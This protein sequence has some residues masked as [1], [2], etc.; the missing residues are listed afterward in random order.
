MTEK[1]VIA[2][3]NAITIKGKTASVR[4][5]I[6]DNVT[7]SANMPVS[8]IYHFAGG[9]LNHKNTSKDAA[10]TAQ[11]AEISICDWAYAIIEYAANIGTKTE[12]A[13]PS[14]PSITDVENT[15]SVTKTNKG[16]NNRPS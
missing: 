2:R 8:P 11:N 7:V 4:K 16:M 14:M 1:E 5:A 15:A 12:P 10:I 6:T 9:T 13:R 3:G